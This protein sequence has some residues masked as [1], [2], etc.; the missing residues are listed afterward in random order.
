MSAHFATDVLTDSIKA[1]TI[2]ILIIDL[3]KLNWIFIDKNV[4]NWCVCP[5]F[6]LCCF[7]LFAKIGELCSMCTKYSS[8]LVTYQLKYHLN[9]ENDVCMC[10]VHCRMV[11]FIFESNCIEQQQFDIYFCGKLIAILWISNLQSLLLAGKK[12]S[13]DIL[14]LCFPMPNYLTTFV[15]MK[16]QTKTERFY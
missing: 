7:L 13:A 15:S 6:T 11:T 5:F 3:S 16:M 1:S 14:M 2:L 10:N 9:N 4:L 12:R 8:Q